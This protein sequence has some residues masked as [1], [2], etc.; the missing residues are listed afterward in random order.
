VRLVPGSRF[1]R[2]EIESRLGEG[3]VGVVYLARDPSLE[4]KVA[5]KLLHPA[6]A[7]DPDFRARFVAEARAAA[8]LDHPHVLPVYEAGEEAGQLYLAMRYV[9]GF[10]LGTL[11][12]REG[13][14]PLERTLRF[15][16]QIASALDAAHARGLVHRDVKPTNVLIAPGEHAYLADFGLARPTT[17]YSSALTRPGQLVGSVD[18]LAPELLAGAQ[19]S[20]RS[21]IYALGIVAFEMFTGKLPFHGR[22]AQEMMIAR[23]RGRPLKLRQLRPDLPEGLERTL[24]RALESDADAR[25]TTALE[26]ADAL[27]HF[28]EGGLLSK[29]KEKLK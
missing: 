14:L 4:R 29:I 8:A 13:A 12:A 17:P 22:N 19:A 27:S 28:Q 6:L 2:Y 7:V 10:D 21:D 11:L 24:G 26:F 23:L 1:A 3:G 9:A 18:Y 5:L 15:L 20:A 25:Y 16:S